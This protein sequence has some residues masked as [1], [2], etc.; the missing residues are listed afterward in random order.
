MQGRARPARF[1]IR[2][3]SRFRVSRA[4]GEITEA[5]Q[6]AGIPVHPIGIGTWGMGGSRLSDGA[7]FASYDR[8]G[9]EAEAIRISLARGQNH[10]DTAQLYGAGHTEEIV[11]A[12]IAGLPRESFFLATKVWKSHAASPL[13]MRR[14]LEDSLRKLG[15][16]YVDMVYT[17]AYWDAIPPKATIEGLDAV[18][19][20]GLARA[21]AVSNFSLEQLRAASRI[22]RHPIAANQLHYNV[23][24]RGLVT[25]QMLSFCRTHGVTIVAY[26]PVE[27]ALLADLADN[28]VVLEIAG[29]YGRTPAQIAINWLIGQQGVVTIPKATRREHIEENL[30]ATDFELAPSDRLALDRVAVTPP[31]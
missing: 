1:C 31:Q 19:D 2:G 25:E 20:E 16:G 9:E 22:A 17:H 15:V 24:E 29:R 10:I 3:A 12:A 26:R 13:A 30:G 7:V 18:V 21:M 14:S 23:L 27:R 6:I 8:D 28:P 5:K 4:Q 11:G